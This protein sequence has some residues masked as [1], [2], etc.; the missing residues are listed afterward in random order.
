[1]VVYPKLD[2]DGNILHPEEIRALGEIP[3][4]DLEPIFPK[5]GTGCAFVDNEPDKP[6]S[7]RTE[8]LRDNLRDVICQWSDY[9]KKT[10]KR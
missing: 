9:Q 6:L 5:T 2:K 7:A 3:A 8:C 10:K 4:K 1:M